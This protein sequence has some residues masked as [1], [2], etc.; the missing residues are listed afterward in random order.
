MSALPWPCKPVDEKLVERLAAAAGIPAVIARLLVLRGVKEPAGAGVWLNPNIRHLHPPELL[1]DFE[2]AARRI[3]QAIERR[4][5]VLIWGHDDLDGITAVLIMLRVLSGMQAQVNYHIPTKGKDKHGL[6]A[7]FISALPATERPG[8]VITVDCGISNHGDIEQL[9]ALGIE[10]I[11]TDHH[12]VVLPLPPAVAVVNPKRQDSQYPEPMLTGAG[13]AL[14]LV[15][16]LANQRLGL[17]P[18]QFFSAQ[19]DLLGLVALGT[20]A[21]RA[22]LTG[23]NR[24]LVKFGFEQLLNT[25]LPAV[26]AVLETL[27][28]D[29][30][31]LTVSSFLTE[32]LPLFASANGREGVSKF[33]SND[34]AEVQEWVRQL[35]VRS[36]E[37]RQEAERTL[38]LAQENVQLGDG[39]LFV[40]HPALSLRALGYSAARLKDR[41]QVPAIVLGKRGD[42]W[43]G[44]CR[45][46]DGVDL[47][48]L[49]Q[50]LRNFFI[51]FGGHK[52]AAGF[53]IQ[54]ERVPEFIRAAER[55]AHENFAPRIIPEN[56]LRADSVLPFTEF[57]HQICRLAPF[58][59]G[60]P[61]PVFISEPVRL[62]IG[63]QGIIPESRQE[64]VLV[65]R[66]SGLE[67]ELDVPYYVLY[68]VDDLCRLSILELKPAE[69]GA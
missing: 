55:Y 27:K 17:V 52:K 37:W 2:T 34:A 40:Q 53:T 63:E 23:E 61:E 15:M 41:Y 58:G 64:L 57:T 54:A 5:R 4:E 69:P 9:Q 68:A 65:P 36:Q 47:M 19:P 25:R 10:V 44:E 12:E 20:I 6:D 14:K 49:L 28:T 31:P 56:V 39:I 21:D 16:G 22:P 1:P 13:V 35:A 42:V 59:E 33:L 7:R 11:V 32:L 8:L 3:F 30:G 46:I 45:G 50:A 38:T 29:N 62:L 48:E 26:R 24:I 67:I 60:N 43:V 66:R 51:D 18:A